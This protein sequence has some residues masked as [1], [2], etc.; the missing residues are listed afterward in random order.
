MTDDP[1]NPDLLICLVPQGL[2][3]LLGSLGLQIPRLKAHECLSLR[4]TGLARDMEPRVC[5]QGWSPGAVVLNSPDVV[6]L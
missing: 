5:R 4:R 6:T 2:G 3:T 1:C